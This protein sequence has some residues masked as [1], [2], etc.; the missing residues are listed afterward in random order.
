MQKWLVG[1]PLLPEILSP[2]LCWSEI[3][4][5]QSIF[6]RSAS[7][8]TR[9]KKGQLTLI[10]SPLRAFQWAWSLYIAPKP[11]KGAQKRKTAVFR[12][13][14]HFARRNYTTKLLCV[15]TV[16]N[17]VV[18]HSLAYRYVLK[19][20]VGNVPLKVDFAL[21]EAFPGALAVRISAF[22]K[23]GDCSICIAIITVEY[24]ITNNHCSRCHEISA[25]AANSGHYITFL[26]EVKIFRFANRWRHEMGERRTS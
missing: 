25:V 17:K 12:V 20:L 4:N 15:K 14:S 1:R 8:V 3:A 5:F 2:L 23:F 19:W 24:K 9:S 11:P 21:S 6:A 7:S 16:S 10:A 18:R 26:A 13:N 22:R